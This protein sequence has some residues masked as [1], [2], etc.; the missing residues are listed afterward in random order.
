LR[1]RLAELR[2]I[3]LRSKAR[4]VGK[5]RAICE[6]IEGASADELIKIASALTREDKRLV[7]VLGTRDATAKL[8]AMAGEEAVRAGADCGGIAAEA[9]QV[10]GG[11]GGG[12]PELG[13][14]GG[15]KADYLVA[16]L[17]KTLETCK[18]QQA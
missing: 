5:V 3:E 4:Q 15:P 18:K 10:L 13:Q 6:E 9:A 16:A 12:K 14:G 2:L 1:G 17:R 8:V 11:G 7:V